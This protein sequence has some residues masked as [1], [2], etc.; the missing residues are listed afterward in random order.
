MNREV[1]QAARL[2]YRIAR[3]RD[4]IEVAQ[5]RLTEAHELMEQIHNCKQLDLSGELPRIMDAIQDLSILDMD[6]E[7][8]A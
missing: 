3:I 8:W 5:T 7:V 4:E 1:D 2:K 6:L